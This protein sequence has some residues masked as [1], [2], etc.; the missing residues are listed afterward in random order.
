MIL[1]LFFNLIYFENVG[2]LIQI[3]KK[4]TIDFIKFFVI[5]AL[6]IILFGI[7]GN[8]LF[9]NYLVSYKTFFNS[10]LTVF[11]VSLGSFDF[12]SFIKSE[13]PV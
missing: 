8:I 4:M 10:L 1:K 3:M 13:N 5:F 2:P 11:S 6:A 12:S 7:V 9:S